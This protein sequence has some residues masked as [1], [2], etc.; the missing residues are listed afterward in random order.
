M[1][2]DCRTSLCFVHNDK[3]GIGKVRLRL[4]CQIVTPS[5]TARNDVSKEKLFRKSLKLGSGNLPLACG[6]YLPKV[7][8]EKLREMKIG[9]SLFAR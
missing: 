6:R 8:P 5:M 2:P 7:P 3:V 1:L 4:C 9:R